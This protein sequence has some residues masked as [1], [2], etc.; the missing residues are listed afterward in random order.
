MAS[1]FFP[2]E[3]EITRDCRLNKGARASERLL[4]IFAWGQLSFEAFAGKECSSFF[5]LCCAHVKKRKI[6]CCRDW[7]EIAFCTND[8]F[9]EE[10]VRPMR[11]YTYVGERGKKK[12]SVGPFVGS[13]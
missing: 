11:A 4:L 10:S 8:D 7:I 12:E 6:A 1:F 9:G 2:L 13:S 5:F 3:E